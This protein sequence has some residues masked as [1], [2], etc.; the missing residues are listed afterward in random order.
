MVSL[1]F[2]DVVE[3]NYP[4]LA[5]F[6]RRILNKFIMLTITY[7][8]TSTIGLRMTKTFQWLISWIRLERR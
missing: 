4:Y 2:S 5:I 1:P 6:G 8:N 7:Q 3:M